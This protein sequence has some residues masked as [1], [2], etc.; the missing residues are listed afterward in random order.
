MEGARQAVEAIQREDPEVVANKGKVRGHDDRDWLRRIET[1]RE[2]VA[3]EEKRLEW[4]KQQLPAVLSDCAA[5]LM[6]APTS[7]REMELKSELEAKEIF[8]ALMETGGR[9]TRPIRL[10][11]DR[12][13]HDH[14]DE[15]L[16]VLCH[17]QDE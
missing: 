7:R 10:V 12:P 15:H 5:S 17:W 16:H 11:S 4:V 8:N 3:V 2:R 14:T 6:G 9:P 1:N 13:G